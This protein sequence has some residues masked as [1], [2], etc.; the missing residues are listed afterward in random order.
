MPYLLPAG[1]TVSSLNSVGS[2]PSTGVPGITFDSGAT[3]TL[4]Q[5]IEAAFAY[6]GNITSG[7]PTFGGGVATLPSTS[8]LLVKTA[9]FANA[10]DLMVNVDMNLSDVTNCEPHVYTRNNGAGQSL[11]FY[12]DHIAQKLTMGRFEGGVPNI[13]ATSSVFIPTLNHWYRLLL[14]SRGSTVYWTF[15]DAERDRVIWAGAGDV[16]TVTAAGDVYFQYAYGASTSQW[17]NVV[18]KGPVT[19][20]PASRRIPPGYVIAPPPVASD[21]GVKGLLTNDPLNGSNLS[22]QSPVIIYDDRQVEVARSNWPADLI[23]PRW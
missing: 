11:D 5:T 17:R 23:A 18:L 6:A 4:V 12:Y 19:A 7:S 3:A 9:V 14:T 8:L 22:Y 1:T 16:S 15:L 13:L 2:P 21:W 10:A 20:V